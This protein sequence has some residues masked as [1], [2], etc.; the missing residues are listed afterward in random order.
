[1]SYVNR[2]NENPAHQNDCLFVK[3]KLV[4]GKLTIILLLLTFLNSLEPLCG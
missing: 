1:M 4:D 2:K 3:Q